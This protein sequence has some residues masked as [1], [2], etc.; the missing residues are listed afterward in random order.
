M[1]LSIKT[2]NKL[3]LFA[4]DASS[5]NMTI[6]YLYWHRELYSSFEIYI[7]GP[8]LSIY[9]NKYTSK[10]KNIENLS[11][12]KTDTVVTGTSGINS[13][14]EMNII[15]EA[16]N[17][18][19]KKTIVLV[20][21]C[22]NF[23][24]RFTLDGNII[25]SQYAPNEIWVDNNKFISNISYLN[26]SIILKP[27][28]YNNYLYSILK[29]CPPKLK[30]KFT[31][32]Y[33]NKY[34]VIL[35]EYLY[36]LYS[37]KFG[38]TEYEMLESILKNINNYNTP[39]FLKLHPAEHKNKFNILLRKYSNLNIIQDDCDIDELVYYSNL[40]FGINS[41]VFKQCNLYK[42][43]TYSI[44]INSN[45]TMIVDSLDK[46]NIIY[47]DLHLNNILKSVT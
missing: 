18:N 3:L 16:T 22:H 45:R 10:I 7:D 11:F 12:T 15:K 20:D 9:K 8:A 13:S 43:P 34:I 38:Y 47:T 23:D 19:V 17:K 25:S 36:E 35:T 46:K 1:D 6:A 26:K 32:K 24:I 42:I 5:A 31:K 37:L 4:Y 40:V 21:N 33:K 44:Q 41:S 27:D 14:Y 2:K 30:H 29:K 28:F 39:V